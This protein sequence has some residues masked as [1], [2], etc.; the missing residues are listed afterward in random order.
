MPDLDRSLIAN[1]PP[2]E[3][4]SGPDLDRI[5]AEARPAR[6]PKGRAV[7]EQDAQARSFFLLLN[8]HIRVVR[9]TADGDRIVMRYIDEGELFGIAPAIGRETYP[10]TAVAAV[11]CVVLAW[12]S[13]LWADFAARYPPFAAC[14]ARTVGDRLQE[15]HAR[16]MEMATEQVEQR[17]AL[18]VLRLAERSGRKTQDGIEI[19][20]PVSRKDIAEMA[21]TTLHTVSRLLSTWEERGL[22]VGGRQRV[23]VT[24]ADG[25]KRIAQSRKRR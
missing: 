4:L 23:V 15:S 5:L 22:V 20:F 1:L 24:D 21:G 10:A 8:G 18:T 13:A 7:F 14:A 2:F 6:Y 16:V 25:L 17:I 3:G 12:P 11:D 9:S 19:D